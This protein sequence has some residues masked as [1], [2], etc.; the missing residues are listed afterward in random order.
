MGFRKASGTK[1]SMLAS[2]IPSREEEIGIQEEISSSVP[3]RKVQTSERAPAIAPE[4]QMTA[5]QPEQDQPID[6]L[7]MGIDEIQPQAAAAPEPQMPEAPVQPQG[8]V[9]ILDMEVALPKE[10]KIKNYL[11]DLQQSKEQFEGS[12]A[13]V[14]FKRD[15][16]GK[17]YYLQ[18]QPKFKGEYK[19]RGI[20]SKEFGV[21]D[22]EKPEIEAAGWKPISQ[23]DPATRNYF[24][25]ATGVM[26]DW[27]QF[28]VSLPVAIGVGALT[29]GAG[30]FP[31]LFAEA[32]SGGAT[33]Y[34]GAKIAEAKYRQMLQNKD[35]SKKLAFLEEVLGHAKPTSVEVSTLLGAGGAII[36]AGIVAGKAGYKAASEAFASRASRLNAYL[37]KVVSDIGNFA[38]KIGIDLDAKDI[39]RS[40]DPDIESKILQVEGGELGINLQEKTISQ[41]Q[42]RMLALKGYLKSMMDR[43]QVPEGQ[44]TIGKLT[45]KEAV[46]TPFAKQVMKPRADMNLMD[47]VE[48]NF[49]TTLKQNSIRGQELAGDL[50]VS[51]DQLMSG[52]EQVFER[53]FN[54]FRTLKEQGYN[55]AALLEAFKKTN[56]READVLVKFYNNYREM[57]GRKPGELLDPADT[58]FIE[59]IFDALP[60]ERFKSNIVQEQIVARRRPIEP[61][62]I[63]GAPE[64]QVEGLPL[65]GE[66]GKFAG[67]PRPQ[68]TD[69]TT[70]KTLYGRGDLPER[71]YFV[72][73][74]PREQGM[75]QIGQPV[76]GEAGRVS[77]GPSGYIGEGA[78]QMQE[79]LFGAP[80]GTAGG[81]RMV[82]T[83]AKRFLPPTRGGEASAGLTF[84]QLN[85]LNNQAQEMV[86]SLESS[87]NT[88]LTG[89]AKEIATITRQYEDDALF[90]I[91]AIRGDEAFAEKVIAVKD[92]YANAVKDITEFRRVFDAK[93][94]DLVGQ[95]LNLNPQMT[96][97][98]LTYLDKK[99][100]DELKSLVF[101]RAYNDSISEV[102]E[103]SGIHLKVDPAKVAADMLTGEENRANIELL[104]G[105]PL[106]KEL[107]SFNTMAKF[108]NTRGDA[109]KARTSITR[110][111]YSVLR[112]LPEGAKMDDYL[113]AFFYGNPTGQQVLSS[114]LKDAN[115]ILRKPTGGVIGKLGKAAYEVGSRPAV[116][117]GIRAGRTVIPQTL[118]ILPKSYKSPEEIEKELSFGEMEQ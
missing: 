93:K 73:G 72:M 42:A 76:P 56:P 53:S 11:F 118:R 65:F 89:V 58:Q 111:V 14:K 103:G 10:S 13:G 50:R 92:A 47:V 27:P 5:P 109:S 108:L 85:E 66:E 70:G 55:G 117:T 34:A 30:F 64:Y 101:Q 97:R 15:K 57:I 115:T 39:V 96:E 106:L 31:T 29:G 84:K 9:D 79:S 46:E 74:G 8:E 22:G 110:A 78:G 12:F 36:P 19:T 20:T 48:D 60:P 63:G 21:I 94:N 23:M 18:Q 38:A 1:P 51:A 71:D 25:V 104:F 113:M 28:A 69:P 68:Y 59:T 88:T 83:P 112:Y 54:T 26:L 90:K 81:P 82:E 4:Q 77:G 105:K 44:K 100:V 61:G 62:P 37:G 32:I 91:G 87:G 41:S 2:T 116:M 3:K 7:D 49:V 98:L 6:I 33:G 95:V 75:G 16:D 45:A 86:K 52:V 107:D 24:N 35:E 99:Q 80:V 43:F 40:I 114:V 102:I 67:I 17:Y